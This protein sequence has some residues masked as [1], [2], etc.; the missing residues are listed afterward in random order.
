MD[1]QRQ[2][3]ERRAAAK[4]LDHYQPLEQSGGPT[5]EGSNVFDQ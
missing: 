1:V 5:V 4:K 2:R 3:D